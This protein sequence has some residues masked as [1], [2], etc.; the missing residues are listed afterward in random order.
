MAKDRR[1]GGFALLL[2]LIV[3]AT[4]SLI[5]AASV[6][7]ARK[8]ARGAEDALLSL[9][10]EAASDAAIATVERDLAEAGAAPPAVLSH[11]QTLDVGGTAV[12]VE[13]RSESGKLDLNGAPPE[14][15]ASLLKAS[16]LDTERASR[17]ADEIA[18]WRDQDGDRRPHGAEAAEYAGAGRGYAPANRRFESNA[19]LALV[20]DGGQD[21]VDCLSDDVTVF[22][23]QQSADS[24][25]A[26]I[27]VRQAMQVPEAASAQGAPHDSVVGGR[28]VTSGEFFDISASVANPKLHRRSLVQ[29]V[30][31]LTGNPRDAIWTLVP[32]SAA[33]DK[34][35]AAAACKHLAKREAEVRR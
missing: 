2:V 7:A 13:V 33:T 12:R 14:L 35:A 17:L 32:V 31:R 18:D 21:L 30:V 16:G 25:M 29:T 3:L 15:I 20:L 1:D 8:Q 6:D 22:T 34:V 10:T 27:K 26:S 9:R 28:V 5:V 11:P 23:G 24:S 19:E 4:L